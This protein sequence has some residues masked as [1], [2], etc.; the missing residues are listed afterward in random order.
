[1]FGA[2]V[3][4]L[5]DFQKANTLT[6]DQMHDDVKYLIIGSIIAFYCCVQLQ[7]AF[8]TYLQKQ[9][10]KLFGYYRDRSGDGDY[11]YF[12]VQAMHCTTLNQGHQNHN[13]NPPILIRSTLVPDKFG[14]KKCD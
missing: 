12:I 2:T 5:W 13:T 7:K 3:K 4:D 1:M 11:N 6:A 14:G 8:I 10:F 9:G